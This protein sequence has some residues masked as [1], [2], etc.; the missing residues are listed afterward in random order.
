M[1]EMRAEEEKGRGRGRDICGVWGPFI[2]T[3][4]APGTV[5][6]GRRR[7]KQPLV[8]R[9]SGSCWSSEHLEGSPL[10]SVGG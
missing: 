9:K 7:N 8:P 3:Q 2:H 6:R 1:R 4:Q 10:D 5:S